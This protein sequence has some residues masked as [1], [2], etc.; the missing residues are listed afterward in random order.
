MA[1]IPPPPAEPEDDPE[2]Y[3][4]LAA[5]EAERRARERGWSTVRS[6]APGTV[7]TMEYRFGRLNFEVEDGT[8]RRSW[9]G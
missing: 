4:G 6:L 1:P 7:I 3:L 5:D 9:K 2:A 8:V